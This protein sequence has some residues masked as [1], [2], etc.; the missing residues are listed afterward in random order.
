MVGAITAEPIHLQ[1]YVDLAPSG[2]ASCKKCG[3]LISL[4]SAR[5][6]R[7]V[8]SPWHDG[9]DIQYNHLC[10]GIKWARKLDEIHMLGMLPWRDLQK[11]ADQWEYDLLVNREELKKYKLLVNGIGVLRQTILDSKMNVQAMV[12]ILSFNGFS[13]EIFTH[14][15]GAISIVPHVFA[16]CLLRGLPPT[17]P[18]C[19]QMTLF[20]AAYSYYCIGYIAPTTKCDYWHSANPCLPNP[21][22]EQI[23]PLDGR[24][25][26]MMVPPHMATLPIWKKLGAI[27]KT[28][29]ANA[30]TAG[31]QFNGELKSKVLAGTRK[32]T[33][34]ID[35]DKLPRTAL[36]TGMLFSTLGTLRHI[37]KDSFAGAVGR[38]G[39]KW[40]NDP[41]QL[42]NP[43]IG[44]R[45]FCLV[46]GVSWSQIRQNAKSQS[47]L[48]TGAIIVREEYA[49]ALLAKGEEISIDTESGDATVSSKTWPAGRNLRLA[50][51][52]KLFRLDGVRSFD[53]PIPAIEDANNAGGGGGKQPRIQR[54]SPLMQIDVDFPLPEDGLGKFNLS[55]YVDRNNNAYNTRVCYVDLTHNK[56]SFYELQL[57]EV[58]RI[59]SDLNRKRRGGTVSPKKLVKKQ[60]TNESE[61]NGKHTAVDENRGVGQRSVMEWEEL[62]YNSEWIDYASM[63]PDEYDEMCA[64]K[65]CKYFLFK[66]WGRLGEDDRTTNNSMA[67]EYGADLEGCISGF[68]E[69]FF[70][71]TGL[72]FNERF[73]RKK[74]VGRYQVVDTKG[75][76]REN[77][78][79]EVPHF[80]TE[81]EGDMSRDSLDGQDKASGEDSLGAAF[82]EVKL[83]G[84]NKVVGKELLALVYSQ[85]YISRTISDLNLDVTRLD[86]LSRD[87]ILTGYALL[88]EMETVIRED[89]GS[90]RVDEGLQK[91]EQPLEKMRMSQKLKALSSSYYA[92]VPHVVTGKRTLPVIDTPLILKQECTRLETL[93]QTME[94]A[95]IIKSTSQTKDQ[96]ASN[97]FC[98]VK[99]ELMDDSDIYKL[100]KLYVLRGHGLTHDSMTIKIHSI[101]ELD[102]GAT[103]P[104]ISTRAILHRKLLWHGTR[105]SNLASIFSSGFKIAPPEAPKSGY[106]FDK[107]VYFTDTCSKAAQ[108]CH[109]EIYGD[110]SVLFLC[111]IILGNVLVAYEANESIIK[112]YDI[113]CQ[114][115]ENE[116]PKQQYQSVLGYGRLQPSKEIS[117]D[118]PH[119]ILIPIGAQKKVNR[120]PLPQLMYN[121]FVVYNTQ[122]V[123]PRFAVLVNINFKSFSD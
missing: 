119:P 15:H 67:E 14:H 95:H 16:D 33:S 21:V 108:Y 75:Y 1:Y 123:I 41:N 49:V 103:T 24:S 87:Q 20:P 96:L 81:Q 107:G 19:Q 42:G 88:T 63:D 54:H 9:F 28:I 34:S 51:Q 36:L 44:W 47:V 10:C 35:L 27:L 13:A 32:Q 112:Q 79:P 97:W 55:I 57:L 40:V 65:I 92:H 71:L 105:V 26:F 99:S 11:A 22:S 48:Q 30:E 18:L 84:E 73:S 74:I 37:D 106:M 25:K 104:A 69:K 102:G 72:D 114:L 3:N 39:G 115:D 62:V 76:D 38:Y 31:L 68:R 4:Y 86:A 2:R 120:K 56:N 83:S 110:K 109:S 93:L 100:L 122:Q 111:E 80:G 8:R 89:T 17:C 64:A 116:R 60:K 91:R 117:V 43:P 59:R 58:S 90:K 101:Y 82:G 12:S 29:S 98:K 52:M 121:E 45:S 23:A 53:A 85:S 94:S 113:G 6:C 7:K 46:D 66:K 70:S 78:D 77:K 118:M 50:K 61:E 5:F